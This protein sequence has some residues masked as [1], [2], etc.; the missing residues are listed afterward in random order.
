MGAEAPED[1]NHRQAALN[2]RPGRGLRRMLTPRSAVDR[3]DHRVR[4][5]PAFVEAAP[6]AL[7]H[8]GTPLIVA[9]MT[10]AVDELRSQGH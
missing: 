4:A 5:A 10:T 1:E 8:A 9:L 7:I 3:H 6:A 2:Y